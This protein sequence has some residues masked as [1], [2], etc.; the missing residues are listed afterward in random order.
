MKKY[1]LIA[2][3]LAVAA[4]LT[5]CVVMHSKDNGQDLP[6]TP[7]ETKN[8]QT[9]KVLPSKDDF[10]A[11]LN[12]N[13]DND[14]HYLSEILQKF[15][16]PRRYYGYQFITTDEE[17]WLSYLE[18][19]TSGGETVTVVADGW[20]G[21]PDGA[22]C[23][24][25]RI[26]RVYDRAADPAAGDA[27]NKPLPSKEDF[28]AYLGIKYEDD[29]YL[30]EILEKFGAPQRFYNTTVGAGSL[31]F[32][33]LE[34]DTAEGDTIIVSARGLYSFYSGNYSTSRIMGVNER[35]P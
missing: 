31:R 34:Y 33:F 35:E 8:E 1:R 5:S 13:Y 10:G 21:D 11:Y 7:E 18:Y 23:S 27:G 30:S 3:S 9:E 26:V 19:E 15:G 28:G 20:Y 32:T 17:A 14:P 2:M 4:L 24:T 29:R 25:S 22:D 12:T 6:S 16:E